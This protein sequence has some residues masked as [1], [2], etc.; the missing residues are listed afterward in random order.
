MFTSSG[1]TVTLTFL[2]EGNKNGY[3]IKNCSDN[4]HYTILT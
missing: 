3:F 4:Q 2:V 1:A